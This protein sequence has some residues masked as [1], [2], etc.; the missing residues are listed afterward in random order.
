M[1]HHDVTV[2]TVR[3]HDVTPKEASYLD[4]RRHHGRLSAAGS[5]DEADDG[6][7]LDRR[8]VAVVVL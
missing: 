7:A 3:H 4:E 6:V 1:R 8:V 5:T 2:V